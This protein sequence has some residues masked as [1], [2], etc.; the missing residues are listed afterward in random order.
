MNILLALQTALGIGLLIFVHELG[1]YLAARL[2]GVRVD[3]FSLGFGPRLLGFRRGPTDYRLSLVPIG[4]YVS[5]AGDG[6]PDPATA[7]LERDTGGLNT[8][9]FGARALF[10]LGGVL[11][12]LLFALIAFPIVFSAGVQFDAPQ[13]GTLAPGGA[14]WQAGLETGDRVLEVDGKEMYSFRNLLVETALAGGGAPVPFV[15]ERGGERLTV[16]VRP[17]YSDSLG[18]YE[19]G[20]AEPIA[21][22]PLRIDEVDASSPAYAAG[23]RAG[24]LLIAVDGDELVGAAA[25]LAL[26]RIEADPAR[27]ITLTVERPS[28]ERTD[29]TF[30]PAQVTPK[31][32]RPRIGVVPYPDRVDALRPSALVQRLGLEAGDRVI[33][34]DGRPPQFEDRETFAGDRPDLAVEVERGQRTFVLR[35]PQTDADERA[36]LSR[37]VAFRSEPDSLRVLPLPHTP[38]ATAG[39]QPGDRILKVDGTPLGT[40]SE[41]VELVQKAMPERAEDP[42]RPLQLE[43][44]RGDATLTVSLA[45][46][47][48]EQVELGF[49]RVLPKVHSTLKSDSLGGAIHAGF[50]AS[51]DLVKQLYVTLKR[52][53]TGDV[54]ARNLG[55]I[56]TISRVS[57]QEAQD[58]WARFVYFLALLSINLAFVNLLPIPV[59]DGGHMLFLVIEKVKGS[60][61][62]PEVVNYSQIIGLLFVILLMLFVTYHDIRRI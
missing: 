38:A 49:G 33:A 36:E 53:V 6:P 30:T 28:G 54:S 52:I 45:P 10:F 29:V 42:A 15:V 62:S 41:L 12:N 43:V 22:A 32:A 60:P 50:V 24:D 2:A 56:V 58:G 26:A 46:A 48:P 34:I 3:V 4:G 57:Y 21:N 8:K 27:A 47:L 35:D 19:L 44:R 17:R 1:H 25:D 18:L 20:A 40:W 51:V 5:V 16:M 14:A 55:G 23:L 59:L 31:G 7:H 9:G 61:V 39:L 13:L 11:M 37:C